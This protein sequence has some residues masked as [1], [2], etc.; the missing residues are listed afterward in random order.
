MWMPP[1]LVALVLT[2][3]LNPVVI[4]VAIWFGLRLD[5]PQKLF[6]AAFAAA[7]AGLAL[8]GL[9]WLFGLNPFKVPYRSVG[10][11]WIGNFLFGLIWAGLGY[12]WRRRSGQA[13][14]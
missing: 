13:P 10:G 3:A 1:D 12:V 6:I 7:T 4:G 8:F 11:L 2:A 14:K 5:Q 9:I